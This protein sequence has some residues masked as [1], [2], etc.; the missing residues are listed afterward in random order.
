MSTITKQKADELA[1]ILEATEVRDL[2]RMQFNLADAIR[3][4]S[5]VSEHE[6]DGWG[7]GESMCALHAAVTS[8]VARGYIEMK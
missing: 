7:N 6:T 8:A 4:G 5:T 3:E 1:G 2:E